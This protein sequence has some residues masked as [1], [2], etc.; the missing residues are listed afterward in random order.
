MLCSLNLVAVS[1]TAQIMVLLFGVELKAENVA[2]EFY[3]LLKESLK[4]G[5]VRLCI[6]KFG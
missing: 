4:T 6:A 3:D 2:E 5:N 1:I